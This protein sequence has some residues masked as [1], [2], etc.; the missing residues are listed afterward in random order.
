MFHQLSKL[1]A[2]IL[3][4][5]L[6]VASPFLRADG[7]CGDSPCSR[8]AEASASGQITKSTCGNTGPVEFSAAAKDCGVSAKLDA[9]TG[10]PNLGNR[11]GDS[12]RSTGW[13]LSGRH[14][15][16]PM[17]CE[18]QDSGEALRFECKS[19]AGFSCTAD[20]EILS[21]N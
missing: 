19:E 12:F 9:R 20:F 18:V 16:S 2:R 5:A 7:G 4:L 8:Y 1:D 3:V 17:R 10:L 21:G 13:Y 15:G 6:M 11:N 14:D